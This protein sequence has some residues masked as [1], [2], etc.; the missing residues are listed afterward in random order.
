MNDLGKVIDEEWNKTKEI[1]TNVELD[2]Y[3]GAGYERRETRK[4]EEILLTQSGIR[5]TMQVQDENKGPAIAGL[6]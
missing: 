4:V 2:Y 1:R 6:N 5:M 3:V